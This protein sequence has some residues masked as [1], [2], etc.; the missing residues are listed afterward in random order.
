MIWESSSVRNTRHMAPPELDRLELTIRRL[1]EAHDAWKQRAVAA[2]ARVA[3]LEQALQ[4]LSTGGLDPLALADQVRELQAANETLRKRVQ[5][6][7]DAVQ[8]M[9]ARLQFAEEGR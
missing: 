8:R 4:Q 6:G 3:E 5:Q 2:E 7:H 9:L 1:L